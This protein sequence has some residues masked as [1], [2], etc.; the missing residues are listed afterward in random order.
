MPQQHAT[1][2]PFPCSPQRQQR[3]RRTGVPSPTPRRWARLP[4][5]MA[6]IACAPEDAPDPGPSAA[7][8]GSTVERLAAA[9]TFGAA[10]VTMSIRAVNQFGASVAAEPADVEI[11]GVTE[12][13]NFDALGRS[14]LRFE[15]PGTYTI[16]RDGETLGTAW[17]FEEPFDRFGLPEATMPSSQVPWGSWSLDDGWLVATSTTLYWW[18][19]GGLPEPVLQVESPTSLRGVLLQELDL[20]GITDAIVW[21]E[22]DLFLL[23]GVP[24]GGLAWGG[25]FTAPAGSERTLGGATIGDFNTDGDPDIAV[26]WRGDAHDLEIL[27]GD[28]LFNFRSRKGP[29]LL[30]APASVTFGDNTGNGDPQ[31]TVLLDNGRWQRFRPD[32]QARLLPI[33]PDAPP[34]LNLR[35]GTRLDARFD[36]NGDGAHD[37]IAIEPLIPE[38]AR[39]IHVIDLSATNVEFVRRQPVAARTAMGDQDGD[40]LPDLWTLDQAGELRTFSQARGLQLEWR[41]AELPILGPIAVG[42]ASETVPADL[43]VAA[44]D[45][46]QVFQGAYA[47]AEQGNATVWRPAADPFTALA[48]D[49][50]QVFPS[51]FPSNNDALTLLAIQ[52]DDEITTVKLWSRAPGASA[53]TILARHDLAPREHG[54]RSAALCDTDLY[55][56]EGGFLVHLDVASNAI[57]E[58]DRVETLAT[59]IACDTTTVA[60]LGDD[61]LITYDRSLGTP[62]IDAGATGFSVALVDGVPL[63]CQT[64]GCH[65]AAWPI[66]GDVFP[67]IVENGRVEVNGTSWA[68]SGAPVL[69][70]VNGDGLTDLLLIAEDGAIAALRATPDGPSPPALGV[71][72]R[73][74]NGGGALVTIGDHVRLLATENTGRLL[75]G[76]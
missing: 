13:V 65:V 59:S 67:V 49:V 24:G 48:S 6:L 68:V 73:S 33:G 38:F 50:L 51:P 9:D 47:Q 69:G 12:R 53:L 52:V 3:A 21:T 66:G 64:P 14:N 5:A 63:H 58:A 70:D 45:R 22:R 7:L 25:G 44:P 37:L 16:T 31:L 15:D 26:V 40:G 36:M 30:G 75:L 71:A 34:G 46:W 8:S 18:R 56:L 41:L 20:D 32:D 72:A 17:V 19:A 4:L 11:N 2:L 60:T 57:N 29:P 74:F 35:L 27:D 43:L 28:G 1:Q 55:V 76:P 23:R 54:F 62:E 10:P 42:R 61:G 39:N